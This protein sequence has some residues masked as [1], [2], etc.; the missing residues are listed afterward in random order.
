MTDTPN[1][2]RQIG[3]L[4]FRR[5][6]E[7]WNAYYALP[8]T[9]EGALPLGSI[10]L[11]VVTADAGHKQAFMDL[12]RAVVGDIIAAKTGRRPTWKDPHRAP[13]HERAGNS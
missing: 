1:G 5:E 9:M 13:E 6:G 11:A 12:M 7:W 4:A 2:L 10:R 8:G 3:R